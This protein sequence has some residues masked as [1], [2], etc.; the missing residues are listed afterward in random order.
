MDVVLAAGL[1]V[2]V[3]IGPLLSR[4]GHHHPPRYLLVIFGLIACAALLWRRRWPIPVLGLTMATFAV[5]TFISGQTRPI[6]FTVIVAMYTVAAN[7]D[8]RTAARAALAV[9]AGMVLLGLIEEG[10]VEPEVFA[11]IA[12]IVMAVAVGDAVQH[13]RAYVL[14]VEERAVRAEQTREETARRRVTEERLRIA[15]ELHDVLAHHIAL[16]NVQAGVASHVLTSQPDQA[17]EALKLI[18]KSSQS[19]LTELQTTLGLLRQ[20]DQPDAPTA[21]APGLGGLDELITAF[22]EAGLRVNR[23]VDGIPGPL[24]AAVDLT[25][26]RIIQESLTNVR[27]H[28]GPTEVDL[29]LR[30]AIGQLI[31]EVRNRR[32]PAGTAPAEGTG[33]GLRGMRERA[34]AVGGTLEAGSTETGYRV[35]AVLPAE[36]N[37]S[38]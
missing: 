29:L 25:A 34:A 30:Y 32:P 26:Y 5:A 8:R 10:W 21:P 13:R 22:T 28:V 31:I 6:S 37:G 38:L 11:A 20:E 19:V 23:R 36:E 16:I 18:R 2:W 1:F 33:H 27:K 15:R 4:G 12:F 17:A 7:L 9:I 3:I 35:R 24:S 14:A